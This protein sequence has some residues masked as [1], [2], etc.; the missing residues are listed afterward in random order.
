MLL[1]WIVFLNMFA[2]EAFPASFSGNVS[3]PDSALVI[4]PDSLKAWR[5]GGNINLSFNQMALSNWSE[6]GESTISGVT[7]A[8]FRANY[9]KDNFKA[10]NFLNVTY[11]MNWTKESGIRK[12]DDK[13]DLGST[14]GYSAFKN[15]Y[16]SSNINLKSQC[17]KGYKYPDDSTRVSNFFAPANLLVSLGLEYKPYENMSLFLSPASGKFIFVMDR[18][19]ADQGAFGVKPAVRDTSGAVVEPGRNFRAEFG[20]N[21]IFSYRAE[22][23]KNVDFDSKIN[24]YNNYLDYEHANRWN[25]DLDWESSF[26]FK[27]NSH[28]SSNLYVHLLYD[29]NINL[30]TYEVIDGKKTEVGKGPKLQVKENFG[31]GISVRI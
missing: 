11:G 21:V 24:L 13:I 20:I 5:Y 8:K 4:V 18:E 19:L 16:Y 1:L 6:G 22:I 7:F 15:W 17:S 9:S 10:D 26:N 25:I 31:I 23:L 12:T 30:P 14:W 28:L 27:I 29:H 2:G 3:D